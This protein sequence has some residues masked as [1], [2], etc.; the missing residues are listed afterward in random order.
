MFSRKARLQHPKDRLLLFP[1]D[2]RPM[3]GQTEFLEGLFSEGSQHPS[4]VQRLRGL[5][6]VVAG[7]CDGNQT[8][9]A[10]VV[11]LTQRVNAEG[12]L[13]IVIADEPFFVTDQVR[14]PALVQ[15]LGHISDGDVGRL[16]E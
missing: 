3:K 4:S 7:G 1:A 14:L 12:L 9:C 13:N 16:P 5:T 11:S 15:H 10:E 8:Y 2:I 6:I